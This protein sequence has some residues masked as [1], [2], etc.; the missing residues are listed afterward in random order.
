[1]VEP[2]RLREGDLAVEGKCLRVPV[3]HVARLVFGLAGRHQVVGEGRH[4]VDARGVEFEGLPV[5]RSR[6]VASRLADVQPRL[7]FPCVRTRRHRLR[8]ALGGGVGL[9]ETAFGE[10]PLG[11]DDEVRIAGLRILRLRVDLRELVVV[12]GA[13]VVRHHRQ[14]PVHALPEDGRDHRAVRSHHDHVRQRVKK[15]HSQAPRHERR[16]E[17]DRYR[18]VGTLR[19]LAER[20][21]PAAHQRQARLIQLARVYVEP[22]ETAVLER[23]RRRLPRDVAERVLP[24]ELQPRPYAAERLGRLD[25]DD[26]EI[27]H[28]LEAGHAVA[29]REPRRRDS[30]VP[31]GLPFKLREDVRLVAYR[32]RVPKR[33]TRQRRPETRGQD[34]HFRLA[35]IAAPYARADESRPGP[36]GP[37]AHA[38]AEEHPPVQH[39]EERAAAR[40]ENERVL[41]ASTDGGIQ[42]FNGQPFAGRAIRLVARQDDRAVL[43]EREHHRIVFGHIVQEHGE[44]ATLHAELDFKRAFRKGVGAH[45][46][47]LRACGGAFVGDDRVVR[48]LCPQADGGTVGAWYA[49]APDRA[50][51][52]IFHAARLRRVVPAAGYR[53][54]PHAVKDAHQL[55]GAPRGIHL[56][57]REAARVGVGVVVAETVDDEPH[58]VEV[59]HRL[60]VGF[61]QWLVVRLEL[62]VV[63]HWE[64]ERPRRAF[65]RVREKRDRR[66]MVGADAPVELLRGFKPR[67][68]RQ[69]RGRG[70]EHR[71]SPFSVRNDLPRAM[72]GLRRQVP[73]GGCFHAL[74]VRRED[75]PFHLLAHVVRHHPHDGMPT[76]LLQ[77][78]AGG[79]VRASPRVLE[80]DQQRLGGEKAPLLVEPRHVVERDR[81]VPRRNQCVQLQLEI[82]RRDE[83]PADFRICRDAV[84]CDGHE[85]IAL[86]LH[87]VQRRLLHALAP[88]P[89]YAV[90]HAP[91]RHT[92]AHEAKQH[93]PGGAVLVLAHRLR[94][95]PPVARHPGGA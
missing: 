89:V 48:G 31:E 9:K 4:H 73:R 15:T 91:C 50:P 17:P 11:P 5:G 83:V 45:H 46:Q 27:L 1:M 19:I 67:M 80:R 57:P 59:L 88:F 42:G 82:L 32:L 94:A 74:Q 8:P 6:I 66:G 39:R 68:V 71:R 18:H 87:L 78:A 41:A 81:G 64:E 51:P 54:R 47:R 28:E 61:P 7:V 60:E 90:E 25:L 52:F 49:L 26:V 2:T 53:A 58:F 92:Q 79:E 55:V 40:D 3:Q 20:R 34:L 12:D 24:G 38:P 70:I 65:E 13:L 29:R 86:A 76:P 36:G 30:V 21:D 43:S 44:A 69:P 16:R 72:V 14:E 35:G 62:S 93:E 63:P 84:V 33:E 85:R 22:R 77:Y 75:D 23:L 10:E 37:K 56:E 95:R